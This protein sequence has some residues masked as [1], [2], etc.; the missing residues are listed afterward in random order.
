VS[1]EEVIVTHWMVGRGVRVSEKGP[2]V[3]WGTDIWAELGKMSRIW[4]CGERNREETVF[5]T[6]YVFLHFFVCF[7][8][9]STHFP[10]FLFAVCES[11]HHVTETLTWIPVPR[12]MCFFCFLLLSPSTL[13]KQCLLNDC[14]GSCPGCVEMS[15]LVGMSLWSHCTITGVLEKMLS[16]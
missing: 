7:Q 16:S 9:I 11:N 3:S 6:C 15:A 8:Q 5:K 13:Y 4:T 14:R 12:I 10:S 2:G 1:L